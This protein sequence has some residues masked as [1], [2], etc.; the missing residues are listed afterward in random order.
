MQ[1]YS[2]A[3]DGDTNSAGALLVREPDGAVRPAHA[4]WCAW[5]RRAI[6]ALRAQVGIPP[7]QGVPFKER[8]MNT[9]T[10]VETQAVAAVENKA[11]QAVEQTAAELRFIPLARLRLSKR[12]VRKTRAPVDALAESIFRVG[13]LQ[14]LIVVPLAGEDGE[15]EVVASGRRYAFWPRRSAS[16]VTCPSLALSSPTPAPCPSTSPRTCS[17]RTCTRTTSS[18]RSRTSFGSWPLARWLLASYALARA[19]ASVTAGYGPIPSLTGLP[20]R[21]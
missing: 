3:L 19:C 20:S 8:I 16:P 9:T 6:P 1:Q 5:A 21:S 14:N 11:V 17:A 4:A 12:D 18:R 7:A 2:L 10:V 15:Y 13:L